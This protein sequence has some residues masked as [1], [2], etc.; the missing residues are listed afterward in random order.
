MKNT[1]F[2]VM[3]MA[4]LMLVSHNTYSQ[5]RAPRQDMPRERFERQAPM[6]QAGNFPCV[7]NLTDEQKAKVEALRATQLEA[8]LQHRNQMAELQ[9]RKRTLMTQKNP[10]MGEINQVIDNMQNLQTK[11]LKDNASHHQQIRSLLTDEQ[12]LQFDTR[13][14]RG[15]A[16]RGGNQAPGGRFRQGGRGPCMN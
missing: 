15:P 2:V 16:M 12:R 14:G 9:A 11:R 8:G 10:N 1:L 13:A 6:R 4:G 5:R 3:M 7:A